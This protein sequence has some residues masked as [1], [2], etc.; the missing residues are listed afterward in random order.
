MRSIVLVA[1]LVMSFS[2]LT[3]AGTRYRCPF[4]CVMEDGTGP[5]CGEWM[6]NIVEVDGNGHCNAVKC[7]FETG[8]FIESAS[9]PNDCYRS[10][11]VPCGQA[12]VAEAVSPTPKMHHKNPQKR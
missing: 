1:V 3:N 12:P 2:P 11:Q 10:L 5:N 9:C 7:E 4:V 8:C 6:F